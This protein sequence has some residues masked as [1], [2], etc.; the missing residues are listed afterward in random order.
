[1]AGDWNTQIIEEFRANQGKVGGP[2]AGHELLLLTTTGARSGLART[3]PLA[4]IRD[5]DDIVVIASK[6]G[7]PT[8]PDWLHNV[9][10]DPEVTLEIGSE[11]VPATATPLTDGPERD[12]LFAAMV[13]VMPGFAEYQEK[14]DRIIP[15]VKLRPH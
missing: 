13:E 14:T 11:T 5:G 7:A 2:F 1:M 9:R 3:N 12:R 15:V 8:N 6:A 10:A 4:F